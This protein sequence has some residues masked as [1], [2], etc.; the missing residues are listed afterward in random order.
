MS[1]QGLQTI[2]RISQELSEELKSLGFDVCESKIRLHL[3]ESDVIPDNNWDVWVEVAA[4]G[5]GEI[6]RN[7]QLVFCT[8]ENTPG[9]AT[10]RKY[11]AL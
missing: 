5:S 8:Q 6:L 10:N 9:S 1:Y 4:R 2:S 3:S 7:P 11:V